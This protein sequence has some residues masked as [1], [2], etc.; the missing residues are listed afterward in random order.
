MSQHSA[1]RPTCEF[2]LPDL[3][4]SVVGLHGVNAVVGSISRTIVVVDLGRPTGT[5]QQTRSDVTHDPTPATAHQPYRSVGMACYARLP[6]GR[7]GGDP[8]MAC[9]GVRGSNPLS[10]TPGQQ[11]S[12]PSTATN[13]GTRAASTQQPPMRG[14]CARPG[15]RSRDPPSLGLSPDR[16]AP[17]DCRRR[18]G[19]GGRLR[20]P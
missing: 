12:P 18:R 2:V 5:A 6:G 13:P 15:R 19:R 11:A 7:R 8:S 10:S 16:R 17:L 14:Q 1:G 3:A 9:K 20:G 4:R